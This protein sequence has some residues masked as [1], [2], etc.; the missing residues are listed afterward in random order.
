MKPRFFGQIDAWGSM[1]R[2]AVLGSRRLRGAVPLTIT[3]L[4]IEFYDE[5]AYAIGGAAL[6]LLRSDLALSYAQVGL[7][8]GLPVLAN[9]ILEPG[10]MLLGDT[11][12]RRRLVIGG[13]LLLALSMAVIAGGRT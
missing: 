7:L 5:L 4:I 10:L 13:G 12:M 1:R 3:F 8:L 6:P 11:G 9:T 2:F